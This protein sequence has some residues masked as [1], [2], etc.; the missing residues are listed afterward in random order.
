MGRVRG[1]RRRGGVR[2][3]R[4]REEKEYEWAKGVCSGWTTGDEF[5]TGEEASEWSKERK[6]RKA[7]GKKEVSFLPSQNVMGLITYTHTL[8]L[9]GLIR[10]LE[11]ST[12]EMLSCSAHERPVLLRPRQKLLQCRCR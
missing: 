1:R 8:R 6:E 12:P 5:M 9:W 4:G 2:R 7:P 10:C 11:F 3:R